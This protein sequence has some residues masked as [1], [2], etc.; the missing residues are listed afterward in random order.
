RF[1]CVVPHSSLAG[2]RD[3]RAGP[4]RFFLSESLNAPRLAVAT[5]AS[6]VKAGGPA[7]FLNGGSDATKSV[8]RGLRHDPRTPALRV[9]KT[10]H[11]TRPSYPTQSP[12][13]VFRLVLVLAHPRQKIPRPLPPS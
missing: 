2:S 6:A 12:E 13:P 7:Q 5:Q 1:A 10:M 9:L 3:M 4:G 8:D 11:P